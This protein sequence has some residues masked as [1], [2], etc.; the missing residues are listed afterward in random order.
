M[1]TQKLCETVAEEGKLNRESQARN[2]EKVNVVH[3]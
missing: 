1:D 3:S 2:F